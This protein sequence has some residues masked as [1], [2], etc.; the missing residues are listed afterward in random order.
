MEKQ[1]RMEERAEIEMIMASRAGELE[2]LS[3]NKSAGSNRAAALRNEL[4]ATTQLTEMEATQ[5]LL[6]SRTCA[7]TRL[8]SH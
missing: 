8:Y 4:K 3:S 7:P 2:H 6:E 5:R 1:R